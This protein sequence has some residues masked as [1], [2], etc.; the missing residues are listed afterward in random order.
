MTRQ[1]F[2]DRAFLVLVARTNTTVLDDVTQADQALLAR[3]ERWDRKTE[4]EGSPF[5]EVIPK[6]EEEK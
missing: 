6:E 2:W 4:L 3:D 1:E 5:A